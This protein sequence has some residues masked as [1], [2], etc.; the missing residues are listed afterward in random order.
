[1]NGHRYYRTS[2]GGG[3]DGKGFFEFTGHSG[4]GTGAFRE[5]GEVTALF[6]NTC[7]GGDSLSEPHVRADEHD[8]GA[9]G[10][11]ATESGIEVF[12]FGNEPDV[13]SGF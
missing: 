7:H 12:V 3:D 11:P 6:Q 10:K 13:S 9:S 2:G 5:D 8:L 4:A 1:M